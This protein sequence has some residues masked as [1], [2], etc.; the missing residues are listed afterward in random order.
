LGPAKWLAQNVGEDR[1]GWRINTILGL[2]E[3][4]AEGA[5]I[6]ILPWFIAQTF[7]NLIALSEPRAEHSG[8]LWLLT[9][10]D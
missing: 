2:A 7:P 3:A 10:P 6:G 8:A 9:H 5:G 1:I 4:V